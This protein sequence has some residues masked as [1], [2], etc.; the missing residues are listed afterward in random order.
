[1]PLKIDKMPGDLL[2]CILLAVSMLAFTL[3]PLAELPVRIPL[4]LAMVLFVPGY[5][6]IAALFPRK[7]DLEGLERAALSFGRASRLCLS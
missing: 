5:V 6:F 3:T 2:A 7:T 4:G 1:M